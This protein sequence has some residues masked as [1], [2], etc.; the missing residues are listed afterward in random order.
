MPAVRGIV[1]NRDDEIRADVIHRLMCNFVVD[2]GEV[3]ERWGIDFRSYFSRDLE[4]LVP[5][6]EEGLVLV[7]E[8][9]IRVTPTGEL[10]V[11]NLAMCFDRYMREKA[12]R[13]ERTRLQP[14]RLTGP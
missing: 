7:E 10:F 12:R 13:R 2:L 4:L 6:Q 11:R 8:E 1:R 5:Y 9:I 14:N 3:S